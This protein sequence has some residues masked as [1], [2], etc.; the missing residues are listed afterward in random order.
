MAA[1]RYVATPPHPTSP[2]SPERSTLAFR[3]SC[4]GPCRDTWPARTTQP[5]E[6]DG[7]SNLAVAMSSH[8]AR[9]GGSART[10]C[11][12]AHRIG[13][14]RSRSRRSERSSAKAAAGFRRTVRGSQGRTPH[15]D[16]AHTRDSLVPGQD[17]YDSTSG[18]GVG[19]VEQNGQVGDVAR[20]RCVKAPDNRRH[21]SA[22]VRSWVVGCLR[23]M[24]DGRAGRSRWCRPSGLRPRPFAIV[25]TM[26]EDP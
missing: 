10:N 15:T 19:M 9:I 4:R 1:H 11:R 18:T 2:A 23:M 26:S 8:R 25:A 7:R 21:L 3:H 14:R 6:G 5:C 20:I 24:I 16:R 17:A 12:P 22:H 13:R